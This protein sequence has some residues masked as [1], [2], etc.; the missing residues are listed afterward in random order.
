MKKPYHKITM[1]NLSD[2]NEDFY[3]KCMIKKCLI[4][5]LSSF[6]MTE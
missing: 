3:I 2:N 5:A 6:I 4:K 1:H